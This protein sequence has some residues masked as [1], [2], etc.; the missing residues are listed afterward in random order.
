MLRI[1]WKSHKKKEHFVTFIRN[2]IENDAMEI[3]PHWTQTKSVVFTIQ[4]NPDKIRAVF[5]FTVKF[6]RMSLNSVLFHG[7]KFVNA[8]TGV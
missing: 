2:L 6:H 1:Y 8:L 4:N 3:A 7:P 5:D